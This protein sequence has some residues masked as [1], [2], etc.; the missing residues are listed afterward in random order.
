MLKVKPALKIESLRTQAIGEYRTM[1]ISANHQMLI[2]LDPT[3][4]DPKMACSANR[5]KDIYAI[6]KENW[7]SMSTIFTICCPLLPRAFLTISP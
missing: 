6:E 1:R 2:G 4:L 5:V 7:T 3:V